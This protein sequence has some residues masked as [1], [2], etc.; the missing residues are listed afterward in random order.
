MYIYS[1]IFSYCCIAIVFNPTAIESCKDDLKQRYCNRTSQNK[2]TKWFDLGFDYVE[3]IVKV[4]KV[5]GDSYIT[6]NDILKDGYKKVVL[7]EGDPGAGKTTFAFQICKKWAEGELLKE[8]V[9][10]WVP[11]RHY[12]SV[13]SPSEL[14]EKLGCPEMMSY[15]QQNKGKGLVLILDGWDEL[16]NHLQTAS[17][18]FFRSIIFDSV[19]PF[20]YSTI[21]VTS[22]PSCSGE[23]AVAVKETNSYYQILGFDWLKGVNYIKAYFCNERSAESLLAFLNSSEYLCQQFYLPISVAIMRLVYLYGKQIPRTRSR[24]YERFVVLCLRSH[25]PDTCRQDF[26]K[27]NEIC[28]IPEKMKPIFDNLCKIAFDMLKDKRLVLYDEE[29]DV[30][31][32]GMDNLQLEQFDGFG[33]L[34]IDHCIGEQGTM[35]ACYS[36]IHRPVQELLAAIFILNAGITNDVLDEHFYE[37]SYLLNVFPFLFGLVSKEV[38]R[39]LGGKLK[40]KFIKSGRNNKFL[41]F[42]LH[43]LFEAH[44]E[45]LCHEF[46]QKFSKKEVFNLSLRSLCDC[47][48][49]YYFISK[50]GVKGLNVTAKHDSTLPADV[51]FEIMAKYI[52]CSTCI[53]D[54]IASFKC[55]IN[56]LSPKGVDQFAKVLWTQRNLRSLMFE[57]DSDSVSKLC[58]C[59]S[60]YNPN[61]TN[62]RLP[63]ALLN[64]KDLES[65]GSLISTCSSLK[66]LHLAS[67]ETAQVIDLRSSV[68]FCKAVHKTKSLEKLTMPDWS[69]S[70]TNCVVFGNIIRRNC[71]LKE[72]H[73]KV[74]TA[75]C[76]DPILNGLANN[77]SITSF[78]VWP[79]VTGAADGLGDCLKEFSH[80]LKT[81]DFIDILPPCTMPLYVLWSSTQVISICTGLHANI[82]VETMDISGC[83]VDTEAGNAVCGMLSQN[84]T[85]KHLFLNPVH[86]EKQEAI[87]MID[88]CRTNATLELLSLV[89]WPPKAAVCYSKEG[90]NPFQFSTNEEVKS[91]L[92]MLQQEKDKQFDVYWLAI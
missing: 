72:L 12:K 81:V 20:T 16:P 62:L 27:F 73:M 23:I 56:T 18:S 37:D 64:A 63:Q 57:C 15:A 58:D 42:I 40:E 34:H 91:I 66:S 33:L 45:T 70:Q 24:L 71:S 28:N 87:A 32:D 82:T 92:Q 84:T 8:D 43:C 21:I 60:K 55:V 78:R 19:E 38:V 25:V 54:Q 88:S 51:C 5:Q 39:T 22:R 36:F 76:L 47:H 31:Q 68:S 83:Y 44:D 85:L 90:E 4:K 14:F 1:Y 26:K 9:V 69:L 86:L 80:P 67:Y 3:P 53:S 7:I 30:M 48:C 10:F 35:K 65:V 41:S 29:M 61:I 52:I 79:R 2:Y 59:V 89:R 46:G 11:F 74:A 50:C 13:T 6:T 17:D 75:N 77:R 49:A